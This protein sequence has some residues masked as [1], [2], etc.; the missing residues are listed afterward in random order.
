MIRLVEMVCFGVEQLGFILGD[1]ICEPID[2]V[3]QTVTDFGFMAS[4]SS[5]YFVAK[6]SLIPYK[7]TQEAG[8][9]PPYR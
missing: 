7:L 8:T 1:K 5:V 9:M 3:I 2:V 6:I 4:R